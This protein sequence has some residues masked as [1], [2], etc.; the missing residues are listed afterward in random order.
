MSMVCNMYVF[1][2]YRDWN[3]LLAARNYVSINIPNDRKLVALYPIVLFYVLIA[4]ML[5]YMWAIS[6]NYILIINLF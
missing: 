4:V 6:K 5:M 3:V 1:V 2:I